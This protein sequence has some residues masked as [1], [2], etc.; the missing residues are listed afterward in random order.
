ML[1]IK[2]IYGREMYETWYK[3]SI[4]LECGLDISPVIT[5]QFAYHEY[6]KGFEAMRSGN[7]GKVL[8]D[9]RQVS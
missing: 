6:E 4:M 3:M 7:C 8:L 1:T 9:W 2:G 5:H